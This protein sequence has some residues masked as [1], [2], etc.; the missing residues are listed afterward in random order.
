MNHHFLRRI[1]TA[2][3]VAA[4][5]F[6]PAS[7][8]GDSYEPNN[9]LDTAYGPIGYNSLT[10]E[11]SGVVETGTDYDAFYFYVPKGSHPVNFNISNTSGAGRYLIDGWLFNEDGK[12]LG[13]AWDIEPGGVGS[14]ALTLSGPSR[15]YFDIEPSYQDIVPGSTYTFTTSPQSSFVKSLASPSRPPTSSSP[16]PTPQLIGPVIVTPTKNSNCKK[17]KSYKK[18]YKRYR[19]IYKRYSKKAKKARTTKSKRK[20]KRTERKYRKRYKQYKKKYKRAKKRC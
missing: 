14:I 20:L 9:T 4:L 3:V 19:K 15:Y 12:E 16:A 5:L 7:V 18:K 17:A 6:L 11:F 8:F 13:A 2:V 10:S 1:C